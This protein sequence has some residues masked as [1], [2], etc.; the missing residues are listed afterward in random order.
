M[1]NA[2]GMRTY[3]RDVIGITDP[4]ERREAIRQEGLETIGDFVEF[5]KE[6]VE[7][8]CASVR[9]PGGTIPN[10]N[11]RAPGAPANIPNPGYA[12][13]AICEKRLISAA[14]TARV[15][16]MIGRE[17]NSENMNRARLKK[18]DAHKK[19]IDEHEDPERLPQVSKTFGIIKA[20]D[21]VPGHLR[22]RLGLE[23]VALSYVIRN[24]ENPP[25]IEDLVN[26]P[27]NPNS[28]TGPSY[29][30]IMDELIAHAPHT[31]T[32]FREDNAKVFQILQDMIAGTSF[33][34]SIKS[35]QRTRDGRAAYKALLQH[36]MGSSKWDKILE[37]A[38]AYVMKR[39]WNGRNMRFSLRAHVAKHREAHNE[40]MRA[41]QHV[42][43]ELPNE[44][45]RVGRLIKSITSK[46]P[47]I[48]SAITHIQGSQ[49]Q[50]ND[51]ETAAEFLLLTAPS[52]G[53]VTSTHR[54]SAI[55]NHKGNNK[56]GKKGSETG[57]ELR[58]YTK[59]EYN[60]LSTA[61]KKELHQL[62]N[63]SKGNNSSDV[64]NAMVAMLQQQVKELEER[65]VAAIKTT[66][67][68]SRPNDE[69]RLVL[70]NP[71]N[72]RS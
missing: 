55:N 29:D 64:G 33:E 44:H 57:I 1:A 54:V 46:E 67:S 63:A 32:A 7:T 11:A 18:Y 37:D 36:N 15:Y 72:Q 8:L 62:R 26:T 53:N 69:K 51:F 9:K 71:L 58:Y 45:T 16:A 61:E 22:E 47:A 14:Y 60:K 20:M 42:E 66:S 21:L 43:Y 5:E 50:R 19:L 3:L 49:T 34:S 6:D 39:E 25:P 59:S 13:P 65:L 17:I 35:F 10:P 4:L 31:G 68:E 28:A 24:E 27:E 12:I 52:A 30:S 56:N 38:E 41:S 48:V 2:A 23:K 40:M 70:A